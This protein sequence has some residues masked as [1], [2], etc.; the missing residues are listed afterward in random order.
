[1]E[2]FTKRLNNIQDT[3]Y[4]FIVAVLTYVKKSPS[5]LNAVEEFMD[6][7]PNALTADIL[8]FISDQDDFYDDSAPAINEAS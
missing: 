5:R 7:N 1:M 6:Q 4:G 8:E 2:E 3:Y